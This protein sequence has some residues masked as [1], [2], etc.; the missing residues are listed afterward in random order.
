MK[1]RAEIEGDFES[2]YF[3]KQVIKYYIKHLRKKWVLAKS[4]KCQNYEICTN[5]RVID[6]KI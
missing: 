4:V 1:A 2:I 5:S 6:L 3:T